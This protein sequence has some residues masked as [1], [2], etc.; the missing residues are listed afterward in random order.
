M[1]LSQVPLDLHH[2]ISTEGRLFYSGQNQLY[3]RLVLMSV[4]E[5]WAVLN[6]CHNQQGTGNH[7]GVTR[8]C[9]VAGY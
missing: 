7:S 4:E 5:R 3:M 2:G 8:D 6:K 9:V 1:L